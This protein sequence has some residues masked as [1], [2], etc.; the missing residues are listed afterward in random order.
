MK[1]NAAFIGVWMIVFGPL[2]MVWAAEDEFIVSVQIGEDTEAPTTPTDL[3]ATAVATTQINLV[4]TAATDTYGVEG[5]QVFRDGTQV[6]TT[7]LTSYSDTGLTANTTYSYTIIAFD[8]AFNFSSSSDAVATTTI[9]EVVATSTPEVS[10]GAAGARA[11]V[12]VAGF[13]IAPGQIAAELSWETDRYTVYQLR[14]GRTTD[15]EL[16]YI[17]TTTFNKNHQTSIN[18]LDPN[19][20]YEYELIAYD[21]GGLRTV[22]SRDQFRTL[23]GLDITPPANVRNLTAVLTGKSVRLAWENP[24]DDVVSVRVVRNP[25]FYPLDPADGYTV[26][27]GTG[28]A[29]FDTGALATT[30]KIFYTVFTYDASG[31]RSSGAVIAVQLAGSVD[32]NVQDTAT[33]STS[34]EETSTHG[35]APDMTAFEI[36]QDNVFISETSGGYVVDTTK[37]FIITAPYDAFPEHLK[38]IRVTLTH[39]QYAD[40]SFSFLLRINPDKTAYQATIAPLEVY[41][42]LPMEMIVHDYDTRQTWRRT[43]SLIS[44]QYESPQVTIVTPVSA[45]QQYSVGVGGGLLA[46]LVFLLLFWRRR[47]E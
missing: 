44:L 31:N 40:R 1:Y 38:A 21:D 33:N 18:D 7:T 12:D 34:T 39:P 23:P 26:Y 6:A 14:W 45:W 27:Q 42:V 28:E 24:T 19:T 30:A 43:S 41:G 29:V 11:L 10:G 22:I 15:Y 17:T 9:A 5:Y 47:R 46:V 37:S 35:S 32:E 2:T 13:T 20:V 36:I 25:L 8:A 4:W 3:V 16:G